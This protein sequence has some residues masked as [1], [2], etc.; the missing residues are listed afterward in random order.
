MNDLVHIKAYQRR[1]D[2]KFQKTMNVAYT[3]RI[4]Y[5]FVE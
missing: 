3:L 4:V 5:T 2:W 1:I